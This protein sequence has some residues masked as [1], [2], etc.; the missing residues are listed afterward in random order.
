MTELANT[1]RGTIAVSPAALRRLVV[2]ATES[3]E[4]VRVRRPRRGVRIEGWSV[5]VGIA[6]PLGSVL[7]DLG[8]EVQARVAGA[9]GTMCEVEA[10]VE[11]TIEEVG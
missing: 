11:V 10:R 1:A 6:A 5:S 3:V 2:Q 9:L 4:G 8:Q 7:C